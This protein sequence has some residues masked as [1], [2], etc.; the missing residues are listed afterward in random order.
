MPRRRDSLAKTGQATGDESG[1]G[2]AV[3]LPGFDP[4][5]LSRRVGNDPQSE[6]RP[7][8]ALARVEELPGLLDEVARELGAA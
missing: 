4:A 5:A 1:H 8:E 7:Q 6:S 2:A 3:S